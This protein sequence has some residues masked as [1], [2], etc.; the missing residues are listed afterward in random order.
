MALWA[1]DAVVELPL[2]PLHAGDG[3]RLVGLPAEHQ[4]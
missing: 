1:P 2:L 3:L 4:W